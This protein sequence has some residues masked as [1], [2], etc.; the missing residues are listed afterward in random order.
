MASLS[1][2]GPTH[3]NEAVQAE[4][5]LKPHSAYMYFLFCRRKQ[6]PGCE[7]HGIILMLHAEWSKMSSAEKASWEEAAKIQALKRKT[8]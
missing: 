8:T 6:Y 1:I 5:T 3:A 7:F 4:V 2:S